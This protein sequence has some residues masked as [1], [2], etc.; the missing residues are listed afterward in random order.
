VSEK[1]INRE[2]SWLEFNKRVLEEALDTKLPLLERLR[3]LAISGS[4]LDE[5]FMI[6][7]GGLQ[8]MVKAGHRSRDMTGLTP[9]QQLRAIRAQVQQFYAAQYEL[10]TDE[11]LPALAKEGITCSEV[12]SLSP[13]DLQYMA[14]YYEEFVGPVLTPLA[15]D[16]AAPQVGL[17][18]LQV[19]LICELKDLADLRVK[20]STS[21]FAVVSLP[22]ILPRFIPLPRANGFAFVLLED[23]VSSMLHHL[24]PSDHVISTGMFRVARNG[25]I[26]VDEDDEDGLAEAMEDV[27]VARRQSDTVR[28]TIPAGTPRVLV[29]AITQLCGAQSTEIYRLPGTLDLSSL[30][31]IADLP[32]FDHLKFNTWEPQKSP[33]IELGE[34]MFQVLDRQDLLLCHPFDSFD[35]VIQLL[36]EAADDPSVLAIKQILYRTAKQSQIISALIRAAENGKQVTAI[37]ELKARF[38]EQRNLERAEDLQRAGVQLVY[39]VRGLKSHAKICM[40]VRSIGGRLKRY[41][42]FGTGNYNE[43][44]ARLYTDISYFTVN[45]EYGADASAFFNAVTGRSRLL[46]FVHLAAAPHS[47]RDRL[48]DLI[49]SETARAK[50]GQ[51]ARIIAKINSLQDQKIIEALYTASK[52]GVIIQLNIRGIC[53]LRPGVKKLSENI[54]VTSIVDRLLEHA[55]VYYFHQGGAPEIF[56]ASADWMTR[57]FDKRIELMVSV[58][59]GPAKKKLIDYLE[60]YF[61]DTAKAR[62]LQSDGSYLRHHPDKPK[63][64]RRIQEILYNQAVKAAR[65]KRQL[66][67][68]EFDPHLPSE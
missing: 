67:A 25:D 24:F 58:A 47:M 8:S 21:R 13:V 33:A 49:A 51:S 1:F 28:V 27:L 20:G 61:T 7:V 46:P 39:G 26:P 65:K 35:P 19:T 34:S 60:A 57:S 52:A 22:P 54:T 56:I 55:R 32:E 62:I 38:D 36:R 45:P 9:A 64:P 48:L 17:P 31:A 11:L 30:F 18:A 3:F 23:L 5:F 16:P 10:L 6:R 43:S 68:E 50:Q 44:T 4:N 12:R 42:H 66:R 15:V 37:V 59:N 53:C 40:I 14:D 41:C 29:N 2:L 63:K